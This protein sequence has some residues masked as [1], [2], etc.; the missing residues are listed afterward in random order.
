MALL[1]TYATDYRDLPKVSGAEVQRRRYSQTN[2]HWGFS[3]EH[4]AKIIQ[5]VRPSVVQPIGRTDVGS[6]K[7]SPKDPV[8]AVQYMKE[9]LHLTQGEVLSAVGVPQRTYQGWTEGD[10]RTPRDSSLGLIWPMTHVLMGIEQVNPDFTAWYQ[11]SDK[12]KELFKS[13]N[14][15]GLALLEFESRLSH[16]SSPTLHV[17]FDDSIFDDDDE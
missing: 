16:F 4:L 11:T 7:T 15:D 10:G 6:N 13:G 2:V 14:V 8:S 1:E 5:L 3:S 17:P 12:A 9:V